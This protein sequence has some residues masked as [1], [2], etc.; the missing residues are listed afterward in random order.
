MNEQIEIEYKI[1]IEKD[2]FSQILEDYKENINNHYIQTNY[3]FTHPLF[4][5]KKY[6][7][8]IREKN[9]TYELT[10]KRPHK[11]Q[12]LETNINLTKEEADKFFNHEYIDN[13]IINILND[14]GI[15]LSDLLQQFSL[16][17]ERYDI[18]LDYGILSL[19]YNEYNG[20]EDYEI[21]YEV[22]DPIKGLEHF[23]D[24]IK[25]YNL[26]YTKNAKSKI[27]RVLESF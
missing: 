21:E 1:L 25:P 8:R 5:Q 15:L 10:L 22:Y 18:H 12:R 23:K 6:M 27:Q 4:F 17:T 11:G 16:K 13:E 19:D 14:N 20:L 7:L 26:E 9:N 2:I 24:I 3:Y